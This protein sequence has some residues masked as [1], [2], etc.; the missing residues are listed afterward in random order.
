MRRK[1]L[2]SLA[3]VLVLIP[4]AIFF[5]QSGEYVR[6]AEG[7]DRD[8]QSHTSGEPIGSE[9]PELNESAELKVI[10]S[11]QKTPVELLE[12]AFASMPS[13][14]KNARD[15]AVEVLTAKLRAAG[16]AGLEAIRHFLA[17]GRDVRFRDGYSFSGSRMST[18]PTLRAA[19]IESLREWPGSTAILLELLRSKGSLWED[20]KSVVR[21]RV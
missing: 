1:L 5:F 4:S 9:T 21:E 13:M 14:E 11:S 16:P 19:L 8:S 3:A 18:A 6:D 20:R 17:S 12:E 2:L 7:L 15:A 10:P